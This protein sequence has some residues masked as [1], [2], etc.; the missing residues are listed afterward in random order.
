MIGFANLNRLAHLSFTVDIMTSNLEQWAV[1]FQ[2]QAK[3]R[4][5]LFCFPYAG[6]GAAVYRTWG[7]ALPQVEVCAIRLPGRETRLREQPY[8][9]LKELAAALVN[10]LLPAMDVPFAFFG[11][12]M[13]SMLGFEVVR[14]LRRTGNTLPAHLFVSAWSGPQLRRELP[15]LHKLPH[16]EFVEAIQT[17]YGGIPAAILAEPELLNI[18]VPIL[19]SD[20]MMMETYRYEDEPPLD[21][22]LS[23][24][25]GN[26]DH[27]TSED[28]LA[29]WNEQ[30][31]D[32]WGTR[33]MQ[34]GHFYWQSQ[35]PTMFR[36]LSVDLERIFQKIGL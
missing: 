12:S 9:D 16:A 25:G 8:T 22:S 30:S 5:R 23:A 17:R 6:A 33:L 15:P 7:A 14:Q 36:R 24:F 18:F 10:V 32:F 34:G 19:R 4:L 28:K 13:G 1:T 3:A 2:P 20:L 27:S 11:H 29:A 31:T 21:C 35:Q 26:Q